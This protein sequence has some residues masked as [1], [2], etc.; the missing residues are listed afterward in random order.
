MKQEDFMLMAIAQA[1]KGNTL[2][3]AVIV[4][5]N[6]V[7]ASAYNT[8]KQDN[9]PSAHAEINAIRILTAKLKNPS[10]DGYTIY[11]TGE[12]CPMCAGACVWSGIS[13][14]VYGA[15][16]KDLIALKQAQIEI[17][18]EEVIAKSF[19]KIKLIKGVLRE[20]CLKLF[21]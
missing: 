7:V 11:T 10:L 21:N 20:E 2:Y 19:R 17:S 13:Q 3:G 15:S 4:K 9:D 16:I 6:K 18:C 5:D 1:K 8:V 12:P 14:I